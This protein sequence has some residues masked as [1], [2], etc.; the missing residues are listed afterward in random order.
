MSRQYKSGPSGTS[1]KHR[2]IVCYNSQADGQVLH[3]EELEFLADPGIAETQSTQYVFTNNATYHADDL[4][5]Y[6]SDCDEI[7]SAKIAFMANLSHYGFDN[8]AESNIVN[9]SETE[10]T[11]DSNIIPYSQ[12]QRLLLL[13]KKVKATPKSVWTEKDQIDNFLKERRG[14]GYVESKYKELRRSTRNKF[15]YTRALKL[16]SE[17]DLCLGSVE[18]GRIEKEAV[19]TAC[20]TQNRSIIRLRHGK[21]P[22]ELLHNKLPDLSSLYVFGALCYPTNDS[23]NLGKLQPKADIG[24]FIG[25]APTK[26]AFWFY[27][28]RTRRIVETI[29]VDF[30][31]LTAMAFEQSSLGPAL[32]EMT[33]VPISSGLVQKPSSSTPYVPPSRN[34]W[35]LLFQPMF[36]ELLNPPPSVDPQAHE[37]IASIADV[38]PPVQAESTGSPSSTTV[39]QD[40]PSPSKS[41]KT[42]ETQFSVIPQDVEEDIHVEPKMYKDALTQSCWIEAKQEEL[43]EFERLE[44][45][46]NCKLWLPSRNEGLILP[47]KHQSKLDWSLKST[48]QEL[49]GLGGLATPLQVLIPFKSSFGLVTLLPGSVPD[50]EDEAE[51]ELG[52]LELDLP[53]ADGVGLD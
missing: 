23:E 44:F 17:Y 30:K 9:H 52:K 5:A 25:Y 11:G 49:R 22:Y 47:C 10:I 32:N 12:Y 41:Q 50:T 19:A 36:D 6:D 27:N 43:N 28:R 51:W 48:F 20:Y 18:L 7:N 3:E 1:G 4:D 46:P 8:L 40:A 2:V 21:T 33:P 29:H 53:E 16:G 15:W 37:V 13:G 38:I 39:D 34:D 14:L 45:D 42:P 35:D 26:K 24:I 31:E